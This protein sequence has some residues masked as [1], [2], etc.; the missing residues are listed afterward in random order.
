MPASSALYIP[1]EFVERL[2]DAEEMREHQDHLARYRFAAQFAPNAKALDICCGIGYGSFLLAAAGAKQVLGVDISAEAVFA[3]RNQPA[4]PNLSFEIEDA[5]AHLPGLDSWDLITCF[6]GVEHVP[7]P[8]LLLDR[9]Y[10]ALRP[11]GLAII[12][13]PN[14]DA[15]GG[16]SG[17]PFH[18]SEMSEEEYR[19]HIGVHSWKVQWYAQI[20]EWIWNRPRWQQSL[21]KLAG[22]DKATDGLTNVTQTASAEMSSAKSGLLDVD[23]GYPM[24]WKRALSVS[25]TPPPVIIAVCQK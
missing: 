2:P 8:E 16:H 15:F 25:A 6:E 22:R 9:I 17:N 13:T 21:L 7:T 12:S 19:R 14:A 11:G 24:P 10:K 5:C 23:S 20:G 18:L 3:A 1:T 4:L